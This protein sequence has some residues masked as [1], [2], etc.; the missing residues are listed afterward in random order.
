MGWF[1]F[2]SQPPEALYRMKSAAREAEESDWPDH[3]IRADAQIG[4][5]LHALQMDGHPLAV[6]SAEEEIPYLTMLLDVDEERREFLL[7]KVRPDEAHRKLASG[8]K[9]NA[10]GRCGSITV[11]FSAEIAGFVEQG[12]VSYYRVPFPPDILYLQ[13]REH[14]RIRPGYQEAAGLY[15]DQNE[16]AQKKHKVEIS[17]ISEGGIAFLVEP[18]AFP[19]EKNDRLESCTLTLPK[20]NLPALQLEVRHVDAIRGGDDQIRRLRIGA[21]FVDMPENVRRVVR[22]YVLGRETQLNKSSI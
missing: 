15:I 14:F 18:A 11:S 16:A 21:K 13:L 6:L 7:D 5:I 9:F 17:D 2:G 8:S 19:L 1:G 4:N 3:N 22:L 10:A 20:H 12:E